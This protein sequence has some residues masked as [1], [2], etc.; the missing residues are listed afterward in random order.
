MQLKNVP[1]LRR[2]DAEPDSIS[3]TGRGSGWEKNDPA[4]GNDNETTDR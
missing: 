4:D 1:S 3:W 2:A